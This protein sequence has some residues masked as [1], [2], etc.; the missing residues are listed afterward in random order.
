LALCRLQLPTAAMVREQPS[1]AAAAAA[2]ARNAASKA[3]AAAADGGGGG[4]GPLPPAP[5]LMPGA[6]VLWPPP[7][8]PQPPQQDIRR[9]PCPASREDF[10]AEVTDMGEPV[11]LT[12]VPMGSAPQ[13]WTTDYLMQSSE[14][15]NSIDVHVCPPPPEAEEEV[16]DEGG[17][18]EAAE[19]Q[20]GGGGGSFTSGGKHRDRTIVEGEAEEE[21]GEEEGEGGGGSNV[22]GR[23]GGR[24]V[25]EERDAG[26]EGG[27][28][29]GAAW[30]GGGKKKDRTIVVDLAGH[31]APG[32]RR[33]FEF[34][35][36]PFGELIRRVSSHSHAQCS[37]SHCT[38]TRTDTRTDGLP[39][40]VARGEKYYLRSVAHKTPAHL[41]AAFPS[42]AEIGRCM[43]K[44]ADTHVKVPGVSS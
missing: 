7:P 38:D 33:N 17:A 4:A 15:S 19:K 3:V 39:P 37:R 32:T 14:S 21:E 18:E 31:R 36:M 9:I 29:G 34:R 5:A 25:G 23:G 20:E 30:G 27:V 26:G 6:P 40:V 1:A 12:G 10:A 24:D 35:K 8:P 42:L 2:K 44:P 11:V 41:P 28:G 13:L 16:G 43:F 22:G